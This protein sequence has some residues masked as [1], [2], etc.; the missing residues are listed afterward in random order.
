M[1]PTNVVVPHAP[2]DLDPPMTRV[3]DLHLDRLRANRA[4]A[5]VRT[6][7]LVGGPAHDTQI[8]DL[9]DGAL[10]VRWKGA[11]YRR[12]TETA[13]TLHYEAPTFTAADVAMLRAQATKSDPAARDYFNG[14]ADR[15]DRY[16]SERAR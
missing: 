16:V 11:I 12:E 13:D 4:A 15:V 5:R 1:E 8:G 6:V 10:W 3:R 2:R 9:T 7:R 14:L